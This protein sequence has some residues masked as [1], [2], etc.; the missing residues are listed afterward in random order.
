VTDRELWETVKPIK[1]VCECG[2]PA[3]IKPMRWSFYDL[4][5]SNW[6]F[7]SDKCTCCSFKPSGFS[8]GFRTLA[9]LM[10]WYCKESKLF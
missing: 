4:R 10:E 1:A 6:E 2:A 7:I 8:V 5:Y 3:V 9:E